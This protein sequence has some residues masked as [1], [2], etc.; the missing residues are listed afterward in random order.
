MDVEADLFEVLQEELGVFTDSVIEVLSG[1]SQQFD[2]TSP[3]DYETETFSET[4][5]QFYGTPQNEV[6][7]CRCCNR[8]CK[9]FFQ[10]LFKQL[11][12][13]WAYISRRY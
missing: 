7:S 10:R 9:D 6:S 12:K 4:L 11:K 3:D 2:L 1:S 5:L 13:P 8:S